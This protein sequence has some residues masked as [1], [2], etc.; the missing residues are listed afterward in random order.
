MVIGSDV[1]KA[2]NAFIEAAWKGEPKRSA[3]S[4]L[5]L[6]MRRDVSFKAVLWPRFSDELGES[7][8]GNIIAAKRRPAAPESLPTQ[9]HHEERQPDQRQE[10]GS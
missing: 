2:A 3:L 1:I 10:I 7:G 5:V 9:Q 6:A 4:K 8:V